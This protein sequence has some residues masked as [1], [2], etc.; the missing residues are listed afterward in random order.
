M[1]QLAAQDYFSRLQASGLSAFPHPA[2]LAAAFPGGLAGM[3]AAAA[4]A[5]NSGTGSSSSS[6]SRQNNGDSKGKGRKEKK[7]SN[8]GSGGGGGNN[9]NNGGHNSSALNNSSSGGLNL[10]AGTSSSPSSY[11]VGICTMKILIATAIIIQIIKIV[12]CVCIS[13]ASHPINLHR[14]NTIRLHCIRN[15]WLCRLPLLLSAD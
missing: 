12:D 13:S 10:N 14:T 5:A 9:N 8:S 1:A 4:A 11:K 2:D 3:T 6:S 7:S 15:F